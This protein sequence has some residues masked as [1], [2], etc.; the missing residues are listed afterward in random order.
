MKTNPPSHV[1]AMSEDG[2]P[3]SILLH[4]NHPIPEDYI[5]LIYQV[6]FCAQGSA[7]WEY[8]SLLLGQ[9]L[10]SCLQDLWLEPCICRKFG[11]D[12]WGDFTRITARALSQT[13]ILRFVETQ[14]V[15]F[16]LRFL[17]KTRPRAF[18]PSDSRIFKQ[19]PFTSLKF[20]ASMIKASTGATGAGTWASGH[21]R[22]VSSDTRS[23]LLG[24]EFETMCRN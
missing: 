22:T 16:P 15:W 23:F 20:A 8:V 18:C 9:Q 17:L 7:N 6:R 12:V 5:R 19:T 10:Q 4:W 1:R 14:N 3:T 11:N 2:F 24:K 13:C 21:Q